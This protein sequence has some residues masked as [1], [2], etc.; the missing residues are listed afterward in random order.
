MNAWANCKNILCIR[1]D[2]MGDVIMSSPAIRAVKQGLGCRITLLTSSMGAGIAPYLPEVDEVITY[3]LP[4]VK[5]SNAFDPADFLGI[6]EKLKHY[7]FDAAII[8]T[9][10]S[11]NP[12]PAAMLAYLA[13]I[14]LRLAYC[15]ENPY[16][17]LTHWVPDKEPYSF[18]KHQVERDL[19]L[20]NSIGA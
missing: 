9:V 6:I 1:A 17:L 11:Q 10:F 20:V 14:P 3:D 12:L 4:W 15:R 18:I 8:F 5:T 16:E 2:N 7:N 13:G 19:A